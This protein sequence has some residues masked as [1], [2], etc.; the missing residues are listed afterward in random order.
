MMVRDRLVA[1]IY[2]LLARAF[3]IAVRVVNREPR[4]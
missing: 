3:E 4:P 1:V 2:E